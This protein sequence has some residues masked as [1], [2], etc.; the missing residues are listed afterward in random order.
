VDRDGGNVNA[1]EN[2]SEIEIDLGEIPQISV[3]AEGRVPVPALVE[4]ANGCAEDCGFSGY[5]QQTVNGCAAIQARDLA[6][7][8]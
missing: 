3:R 5:F 8:P 7:L 2:G 4:N 1:N 6:V